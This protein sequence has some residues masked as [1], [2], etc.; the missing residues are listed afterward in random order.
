[1]NTPEIF[2]VSDHHLGHAKLLTFLTAEGGKCRPHE[3]IEE[4]N[5]DIIQKHNSK[6]KPKDKVYFLGDVVFHKSC[7]PLLER[8]N[9][10]KVLVK[11]NHDLHDLSLY[12]KYFRDIRGSHSFPG[13]TRDHALLLT[14]IPVHPDCVEER[15]K[16]GNIH[17]HLH[18]L[19]VRLPDGSIDPRYFCVSLEHSDYYPLTL[20]EIID[21]MLVERGAA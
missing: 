21:K 1:M 2:V 19:R 14:H 20:G 3:T 12:S 11:G 13:K 17:G 4:M 5:E 6:V 10:D 9:G 18:E 16:D 15:Y 8:M 7:F